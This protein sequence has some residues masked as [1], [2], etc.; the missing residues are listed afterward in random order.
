M[1]GHLQPPHREAA[2]QLGD[3]GAVLFDRRVH[4]WFM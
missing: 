2:A 1:Y 4:G 3:L